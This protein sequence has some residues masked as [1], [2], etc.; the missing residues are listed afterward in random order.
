MVISF[1]CQVLG[2][3]W[4]AATQ[5]HVCFNTRYYCCSILYIFR[6]KNTTFF[7][8][9]SLHNHRADPVI[10]WINVT[11]T[12]PSTQLLFHR[13]SLSPPYINRTTPIRINNPSSGKSM[14]FLKIT[15]ELED[16]LR[17]YYFWSEKND[18]SLFHVRSPWELT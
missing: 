17:P 4:D 9:F 1:E 2:Q 11:S 8:W 18:G 15:N 12:T 13:A 5:L 16:F 10:R 7:V 14:E 6:T 3:I